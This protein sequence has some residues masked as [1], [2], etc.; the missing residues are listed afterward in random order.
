MAT[1]SDCPDCALPL[2]VVYNGDTGWRRRECAKCSFH[3]EKYVQYFSEDSGKSHML[4]AYDRLVGPDDGCVKMVC[5][6]G[7]K[8]IPIGHWI[9]VEVPFME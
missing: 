5:L 1:V 7:G 4:P 2:L 6:N 9:N 3:G 8:G